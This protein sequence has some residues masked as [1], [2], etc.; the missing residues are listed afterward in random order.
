MLNAGSPWQ[1]V[2]GSSGLDASGTDPN[3]VAALYSQVQQAETDL[4]VCMRGGCAVGHQ[5]VSVVTCSHVAAHGERAIDT[6]GCTQQA[7]G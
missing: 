4:E 2:L 7:Q 5:L 6:A 3:V 1:A